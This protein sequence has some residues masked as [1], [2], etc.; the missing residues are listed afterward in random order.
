MNTVRKVP[1][2]KCIG[3]QQ[4]KS[5]KEMLRILRTEEGSVIFDSTGRRNGRGAYICSS[6]ECL[7]KAFQSKA[8]ERALKTQITAQTREKLQE[9][10]RAY[11][12]E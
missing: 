10:I 12:A 5:K 11:Y 4:Q 6:S 3:C 2:R 8:L 9:E 1:L 7:E